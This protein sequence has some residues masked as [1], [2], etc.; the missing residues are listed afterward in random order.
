MA[1]K[2]LY[3][4]AAADDILRRLDKL[5]AGVTRQWGTMSVG[6]M[7]KHMNIAYEVA[8]GKQQLQ[9]NLL[10]T[11]LVGN[12]FGR[13]ILIDLME[14]PHSMRT[15]PE[16]IVKDDSDLTIEKSALL[17]NIRVFLATDPSAIGAHPIFGKM[18]KKTWGKLMYR[19]TDHHLRQ[20][21]C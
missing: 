16:F 11:L 3:D 2:S 6:Q 18:D 8:L 14:W 4:K 17:E 13:W 5:D 15:V 7:L 9:P 12:P 10:L 21:G 19:H 20:F 1:V